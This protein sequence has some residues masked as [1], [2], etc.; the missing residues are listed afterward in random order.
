MSLR[1][2]RCI[3]G[4]V[5]AGIM[6]VAVAARRQVTPTEVTFR[7]VVG[8][9][10][11]DGADWSGQVEVTSY[12]AL[13]APMSVGPKTDMIH[14]PYKAD[15]FVQA[16]LDKGCKLGF[17]SSSDHIST[18]VSYCC[19]LA[20][21]FSRKGLVE[22]MKKR[23]TYAATDN[24]VLDV[25]LGGH[26]MGDEVRT[27]EPKLDVVVLGTGPIE[28]VEILRNGAVVHTE[29]PKG[30]EARFAWRDPAPLKRDKASYYYV[31][32]RQKDGQMAWASPIWVTTRAV[33]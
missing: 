33:K 7:I 31:R 8:L 1:Q 25:R 5:V 30:E 2:R 27:A 10:D 21:E 11:K 3:L 17:Q 19:V 32:V 20:E 28:T 24:I 4:M 14:G 12:E 9:K 13:G 26:I 23:H 6:L 15:G 29:K 18:H 22:A 16:A